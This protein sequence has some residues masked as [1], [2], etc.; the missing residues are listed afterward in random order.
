M[1]T[2]IIDPANVDMSVNPVDQ[3]KQVLRGNFWDNKLNLSTW[4]APN[5]KLLCFSS[6]TFTDTH[7]E[8]NIIIN[9]ILP[10]LRTN[11]RKHGIEVSISD[12]RW[13]VRDASTLLH[14]TWLECK[15]ELERCRSQSSGLFFL[16]LQSEK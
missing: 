4:R 3:R 5:W 11:S 14:L 6:S 13:G 12:M 9:K 1:N 2:Q 10:K 15:R 7:E 16:S 8:R